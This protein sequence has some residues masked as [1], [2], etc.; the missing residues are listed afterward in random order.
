MDERNVKRVVEISKCSFHPPLRPRKPYGVYRPSFLAMRCTCLQVAEPLGERRRVI[1]ELTKRKPC[2]RS[3][4]TFKR[5]RSSYKYA[6]FSISGARS[7]HCRARRSK[8][9]MG[10]KRLTVA[11]APCDF[12]ASV[13]AGIVKGAT[14]RRRQDHDDGAPATSKVKKSPAFGN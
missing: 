2:Q 8:C 6:S 10:S 5:P 14:H 4:R 9:G 11:F 12:R 13:A 3:R 7:G 1:V